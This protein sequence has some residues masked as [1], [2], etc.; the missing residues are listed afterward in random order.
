MIISY[1][2]YILRFSLVK[3]AFNQ[4]FFFVNA[5]KD[6]WVSLLYPTNV[7]YSRVGIVGERVSEDA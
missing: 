7:L 5:T 4:L 3:V 2:I 1:L 6:L